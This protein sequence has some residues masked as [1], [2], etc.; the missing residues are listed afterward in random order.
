MMDDT[1]NRMV[2]CS[3]LPRSMARGKGDK[4]ADGLEVFC[5]LGFPWFMFCFVRF[6]FAL[7]TSV[8]CTHN[9]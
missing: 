4:M 5:A 8:P 3:E 2:V 7:C 1:G 6:V 9:K